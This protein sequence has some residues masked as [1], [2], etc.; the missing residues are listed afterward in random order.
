M[1]ASDSPF[2]E[3]ATVAAGFLRERM[4]PRIVTIDFGN[5]DSHSD[6]NA[7]Q[8]ITPQNQWPGRYPSFYRKLN[9]GMRALRTGLG[10]TWQDTAVLIFTEFGRTVRVNGTN[11]TD[12]GTAGAAMLAG[13]AVAGG[14]VISDWRGLAPRDLLED[15][16][17]YPTTDIRSLFKATLREHMGLSDT[18]I[19]TTVFP[20]TA[21]IGALE[22]LFRA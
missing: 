11:G 4:G 20:Q 22:G 14:R 17:L 2:E 5:W 16:D 8:L 3:M 15:R 10:S 1:G 21:S 19:E 18:D 6:Q 12:H 9:S 7:R 13:G